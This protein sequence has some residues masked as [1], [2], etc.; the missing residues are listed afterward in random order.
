MQYSQGFNLN[1][2][3]VKNLQMK[4]RNKAIREARTS[5][6]KIK[7]KVNSQKFCG[8]INNQSLKNQA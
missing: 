3:D 5:F 8:V 4:L 6:L 1:N 2:D 7:T